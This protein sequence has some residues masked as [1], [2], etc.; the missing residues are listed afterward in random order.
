MGWWIFRG[1]LAGGLAWYFWTKEEQRG[2]IELPP[3]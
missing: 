2:D 3:G 1:V